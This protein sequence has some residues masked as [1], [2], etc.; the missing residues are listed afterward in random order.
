MHDYRGRP[1]ASFGSWSCR[2]NRLQ[3]PA[4]SSSRVYPPHRSA[5]STSVPVIRIHTVSHQQA[6]G[7]RTLSNDPPPHDELD[8][9]AERIM[10]ERSDC[11]S[12]VNDA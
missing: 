4:F 5:H 8:D 11:Y 2:F 12:A 3:S 9:I 1:M 7:F 10:S 6:T